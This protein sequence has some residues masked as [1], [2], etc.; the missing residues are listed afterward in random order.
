MTIEIRERIIAREFGKYIA[1]SGHSGKTLAMH[2]RKILRDWVTLETRREQFKID[3]LTPAEWCTIEENIAA[4]Y[5]KRW[6]QKSKDT[7]RKNADRNKREA[8][9]AKQLPLDL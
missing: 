3:E 9:N 7:R 4:S 6:Q 1:R 2:L 8:D 5:Q